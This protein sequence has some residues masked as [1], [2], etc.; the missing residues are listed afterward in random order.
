MRSTL[1]KMCPNVGVISGPCFPAFGLNME[2]YSVNL[3]IQS[4][5]RKIRIKN[6]TFHALV[7]KL[8]QAAYYTDYKS[9]YII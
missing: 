3:R 4:E 5:Y 2:T 6:D 8:K 1:R 7:T 9:K